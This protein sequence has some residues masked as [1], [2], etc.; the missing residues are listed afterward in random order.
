MADDKRF[1]YE[2]DLWE[3][4]K[5]VYDRYEE[6]KKTVS[7]AAKLFDAR[8]ALEADYAK[9]TQGMASK[10]SSSNES[11]SIGAAWNAM[12]QYHEVAQKSHSAMS[13][14]LSK[15]IVAEMAVFRKDMQRQRDQHVKAINSL[16]TELERGR[17]AVLKAKQAYH[18]KSEATENALLN[19]EKA[20]QD[21][22]IKTKDL[23]KLNSAAKKAQKEA[24]SANSTYQSQLQDFQAFQ[25][26][27]EDAMKTLLNEFQM[28]E[29][30]RTVFVK[31]V[32]EKMIQAQER[33]ISELTDA[34]KQ[35]EVTVGQM[36][37]LQDVQEFISSNKTG[38]VPSKPAEYEPYKWKHSHLDTGNSGPKT[39]KSSKS[40]RASASAS[41]SRSVAKSSSRA[42]VA[43]APVVQ[44]APAA[45]TGPKILATA[46]YDYA[47]AEDNE[48]SF[49]VGDVIE[50]TKKDPSGWWE[51]SC[52]GRTGMFPG[53][54]VEEI[55]EAAKA[56]AP[57]A[58]P[59]QAAAPAAAATRKCLVKFDFT[60]E[61]DDELTIVV[62][63][64][65]TIVSEAEGWF[66]GTNDQGK[67]GLFPAN[68]VEPL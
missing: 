59:A 64:T 29:E 28:L 27:Y 23:N 31:D 4:T 34:H 26:K 39:K 58:S 22:T 44:A 50:V 46:T 13:V 33:L 47:A 2:K 56:A 66:C 68:Y 17:A 10:P 53:N 63:Q 21:P 65:I 20:Q 40:S 7:D 43:A 67:T 37:G 19:H 1:T 62:G 52:K 8:A 35:L 38:L 51:G 48:L 36:N 49:D 5:Q 41:S 9:K 32:F 25:V 16:N 11:R 54:Y 61:N 15:E 57:A 14:V 3:G 55:K 42:A 12:K 30:R 60:A 45:K 24:D 18:Q 6:G